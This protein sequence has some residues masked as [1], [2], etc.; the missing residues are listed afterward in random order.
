MK[1]GHLGHKNKENGYMGTNSG[2][3]LL[4]IE[5]SCTRTTKNIPDIWIVKELD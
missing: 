5:R 4:R 3:I 1:Q 2:H